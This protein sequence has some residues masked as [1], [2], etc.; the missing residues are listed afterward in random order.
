MKLSKFIRAYNIIMYNGVKISFFCQKLSGVYEERQQEKRYCMGV[1]MD[2]ESS[3]RIVLYHCCKINRIFN[4]N[5]QVLFIC[6]NHIVALHQYG[7]R[8]FLMV[9]DWCMCKVVMVHLILQSPKQ[10]YLLVLECWY[11]VL[12][13]CGLYLLFVV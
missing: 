12:N 13:S 2:K 11:N 7:T 3:G 10:L 8:M 4:G 1:I 5:Y 6:L 9:W